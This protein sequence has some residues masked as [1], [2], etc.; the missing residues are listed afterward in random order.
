[1]W[2]RY[3]H[4]LREIDAIWQTAGVVIVYEEIWGAAHNFGALLQG[5]AQAVS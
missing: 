4:I 1:M 5:A 3:L 2:K